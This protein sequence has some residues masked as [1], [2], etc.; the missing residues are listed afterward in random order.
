MYGGVV[1]SLPKPNRHH[2]VIR[3][4]FDQTGSGISGTDVQGFL[5]DDGTFVN[6]VDALA[7]A[8]RTN[9]VLNPSNVRANR[10]FSEDLW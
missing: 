3:L 5:T 8:L 10:L 2:D 1:Y 6:R 7:I 4:I 9:Q